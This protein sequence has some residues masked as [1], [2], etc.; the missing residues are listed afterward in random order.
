MVY[1]FCCANLGNDCDWEAYADTLD[2]LIK[3]TEEHLID[4]HQIEKL[5]VKQRSLIEKTIDEIEEDE[6]IFDDDY[7]EEDW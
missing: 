4:D 7:E 1:Y 2:E 5:T 3:Y 6:E